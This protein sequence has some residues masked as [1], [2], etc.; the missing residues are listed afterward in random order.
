MNHELLSTSNLIN[1]NLIFLKAKNH[2]KTEALL[3]WPFHVQPLAFCF[4]GTTSATILHFSFVCCSTYQWVGFPFGLHVAFVA[5]FLAQSRTHFA[6]LLFFF[7]GCSGVQPLFT[8]DILPTVCLLWIQ[9]PLW[10]RLVRSLLQ[11]TSSSR[12]TMTKFSMQKINFL[13]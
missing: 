2:S 12:Q 3:G 11:N 7:A 8:L 1:K 5:F 13:H 10:A 4:P 9:L 6:P